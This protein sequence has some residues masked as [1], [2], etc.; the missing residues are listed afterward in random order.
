MT[1][2]RVAMAVLFTAILIGGLVAGALTIS[3]S[4]RGPD[5]ESI[6]S[7]SLQ[8]VREQARLTAFAARFVAA[9][10]SSQERFG[11]TAQKTLIMPGMV[12]YEIDLAK[13]D[14]GDLEWD[15][16]GNRLTVIIPPIEVSRP[17]IQLSELQEYDSGGLLMRL[18]NAEERLDAANRRRA[19]EELARQARQALPL[20]LA[21]DAAR[22]AIERS[23]AMP[24]KAAG[25]DAQVRVRFADEPD[26]APSYLDRSRRIE[27]VLGE[28]ERSS[29]TGS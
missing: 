3:R 17:E 2:M 10:T 11:L 23:F 27:D 13:I 14:E 24:L 25:I 26:D 12:R 4:I 9:V 1:K 21:R 19:E 15:K 22:R 8:S 6:A 5:P 16:A 29:A 7:A 20:R 18:T 28:R